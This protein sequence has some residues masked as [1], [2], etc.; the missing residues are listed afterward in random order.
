MG[1]R[2]LLQNGKRLGV[3]ELESTTRTELNRHLVYAV[4]SRRDVETALRTRTDTQLEQVAVTHEYQERVTLWRRRNA[5]AGL[6]ST[7]P[8]D[9]DTEETV[10]LTGVS[11]LSLDEDRSTVVVLH[12]TQ[13]VTEGWVGDDESVVLIPVVAG[14]HTT[15]AA[16][17]APPWLT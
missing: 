3:T 2:G 9:L 4:L 17:A 11:T 10:W 13:N 16:E 5:V 1:L 14:L 8:E 6:G 15:E 12:T 7:A